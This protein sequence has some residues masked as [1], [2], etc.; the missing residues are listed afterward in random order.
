MKIRRVKRS[1]GKNNRTLLFALL[2]LL[3][4]LNLAA[5]PARPIN[6]DACFSKSGQAGVEACIDLTDAIGR[7]LHRL[8]TNARA[9]EELG[10]SESAMPLYAAAAAYFPDNKRALQGL[11]RSRANAK[12]VM[13]YPR[14]P[15]ASTPARFGRALLPPPP[16][17][18]VR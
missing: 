2:V 18:G 11:V 10:K 6:N 9:L 17:I 3:A 1:L 8:N 13:F 5:E 16:M 14:G 4:D 7:D 12:G 15:A